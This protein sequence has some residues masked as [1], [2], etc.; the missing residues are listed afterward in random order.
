[1]KKQKL[2]LCFVLAFSL[3][4]GNARAEG[5]YSYTTKTQMTKG[6]TLTNIKRFYADYSLNINVI[7]ADLKEAHLSLDLLK[8]SNGC[9]KTDTV[10]SLAKG[11]E[12]V[13]AAANADF[14]S[15]Y[16]GS[17]YFSLGIEIKDGTILQSH[18]NDDMAAGIFDGNAL[19][20]SYMD[21]SATVTAQNGAVLP[22]THI[23]KPTDYYGALLM[24]THAFNGGETP[25]IPV[26]M[27]VVTVEGETV[28]AKGIS[29]GGTLP[30]PENGYILIIDDNMTPLLDQNMNV[31]EGAKFSL[32]AT[33]SV[34]NAVT[35]FGGGTM[36]LK[37]GEKTPITHKVNG[38]NPRSAIGTNAD[39][40]VVYILT[41]DGRQ[42]AS[43]GVSLDSLADIC[44][45]VGMVNALN[46]D[47]GGSTMLV[48]KDAENS[49]LHIINTPSENRKV[50]NAVGIVS[51]ATSGA[52]VSLTARAASEAVLVGDSSPITVVPLDEN[53]NP[54]STVD[55]EIKWVVSKGK[56]KVEN[57]VFYA[58]EKG[59]TVCDLYYNNV[60]QASCTFNV[61][62]EDEVCG[63]AAPRS[64]SVKN[65]SVLDAAEKASVYTSDG[66]TAPVR[67]IS[68]LSP[69]YDTTFMQIKN[70]VITILRDGAGELALSVGNT[71]RTVKLL[72]DGYDFDAAQ[73]QTVDPMKK[74]AE[75]TLNILANPEKHTLFSRLVY[76]RAAD[77]FAR[78][79]AN[80]AFI[81]GDGVQALT[82]NTLSPI[83]STEFSETASAGGRVIRVKPSGATLRTASQWQK[84][85]S[86]VENAAE[87]NI[88]I[89]FDGDLTFSDKLEE[90]VFY[91]YLSDKAAEKNI[92]VVYTG[93]ENYSFIK[94]GV[95]YISI[96]AATDYTSLNAAFENMQ[97]L[98]V[99]FTQD[100]AYYSFE[101]LYG[102][103]VLQ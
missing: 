59:Q 95:R 77:T 38:Y 53:L 68:L 23:N 27:T 103:M 24:Y 18:I 19:S 44:K 51:D 57:N 88:V 45:D 6:V 15:Y 31:G 49:E 20:L 4:C 74:S 85:T 52:A 90:R 54:P 46:L 29:Q 63:I 72:C 79:G 87:K 93:C 48:G 5:I 94:N 36:L 1:M 47:G 3:F 80:T 34:E 73:A 76:A 12:G 61:I 99:S 96:A 8:N 71:S 75:A 33:P 40:T 100:E 64:I 101:N 56:G 102:G 89:L 86:A 78:N 91:D 62:G 70:N 21:F 67:D 82:P 66:T 25:F 9:D 17:Q 35:A 22:V 81:G 2:A 84:L 69:V 83:Y 42:T 7:E 60:W 10:L 92:I 11:E 98:S 30:I 55:G 43:K 58:E 13:V 28:A 65:G 32:T 26:G 16:K 97:Y 39:G 37:N 14:F 41:V 50:I